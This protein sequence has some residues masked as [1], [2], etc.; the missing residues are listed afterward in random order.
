GGSAEI[1]SVYVAS[2]N[3]YRVLGVPALVGRVLNPDDDHAGAPP[4]GVIS[5][6]LWKRRF[7]GSASVLGTVVQLSG[8]P[9]TI[10]G[11]TPSWFTGIQ[12]AL[13]KAPDIT[14]PIVLDS[15]MD[16]SG[17]LTKATTWWLQ[18]VGR[19]KPDV[20]PPQVDGSLD[21]VFQQTA[22]AGWTSYVASLTDA[23]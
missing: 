12:Q 3:V 7:G 11:A 2:G 8:T 5:E 6:G 20:T 4:V 21:G 9:V 19:L 17:R 10:V 18:V 1:V 22:R 23:D 16:D 15:R 13:G 14:V